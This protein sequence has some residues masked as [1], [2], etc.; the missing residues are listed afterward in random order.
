MRCQQLEQRLKLGIVP[1][2]GTALVNLIPNLEK[3][4]ESADQDL[5][6]G[7]SIVLRS[8]TAPLKQIAENAGREGSVVVE[9]VKSRSLV[10][11]MTLVVISMLI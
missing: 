9:R 1:G 6:L 8:L 3:A 11:V 10:P 4:I 5:Q 2:G 7:M